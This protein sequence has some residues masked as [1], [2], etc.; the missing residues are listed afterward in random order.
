[1][2]YS[3]KTSNYDLTIIVPIYNE[4]EGF[5]ALGSTLKDFLP[6]AKKTTAILFVDDG[7]SDGSLDK[8]KSFCQ[9]NPHFYFIQHAKNSGLSAALKSGFE[10]VQSPLVGYI[11]ADL[12][13]NPEDF[14]L[15]LDY[16]D[17]Y[18]LVT[19]IR[20]SRKDTFFKKL[21]S[22]VANSFRRMM[23][24]DGA[25]DT[26]CPL[27]I[28]HTD[29]AKKIPMFTGLHRFFPA[30]VLMMGGTY[31]EMPVRHYPRVAGTSKYHLLNRLWGP[32]VDCF[33]YRWMKKRVLNTTISDN[34][35]QEEA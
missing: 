35:L 25:T 23:T 22:K 9:E 7:S 21:Q 24:K 8:I 3:N 34:N 19:G 28:M 16:T 10:I 12:Q 17:N 20:A 18:Q 5:D 30:L 1:M 15:L 33:A 2:K 32:F 31:K 6:Q 14:N 13:T 4:I 26:G 11:D 27:K 29:M